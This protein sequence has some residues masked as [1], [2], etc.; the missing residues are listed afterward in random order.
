[1]CD[2]PHVVIC[3]TQSILNDARTRDVVVISLM[4]GPRIMF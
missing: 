4:L 2:P 1:M 3:E